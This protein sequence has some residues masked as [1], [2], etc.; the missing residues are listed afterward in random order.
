MDKD[1]RYAYSYDQVKAG[2]CKKVEVKI[3]MATSSVKEL[4]DITEG[5]FSAFD[6]HDWWMSLVQP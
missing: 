3:S 6:L 5:L 1:G 2:K 4:R